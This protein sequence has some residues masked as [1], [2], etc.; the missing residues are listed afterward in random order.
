MESFLKAI[1]PI[2]ERKG[3]DDQS[4]LAARSQATPRL[5]AELPSECGCTELFPR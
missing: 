1:S 4:I 5:K 3:V 2:V